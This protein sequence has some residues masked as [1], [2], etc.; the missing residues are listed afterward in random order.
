MC[1]Q[2]VSKEVLDVVVPVQ[3]GPFIPKRKGKTVVLRQSR[4]GVCKAKLETKWVDRYAG[5][6]LWKPE[7]KVGAK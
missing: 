5:L 2:M 1:A 6:G 7:A 4:P 3:F